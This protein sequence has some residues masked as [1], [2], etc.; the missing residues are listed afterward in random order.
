MSRKEIIET[1]LRISSQPSSL[2]ESFITESP[3]MFLFSSAIAFD[4]QIEYL[5]YLKNLCSYL[6]DE[7]DC[8]KEFEINPDIEEFAD[9]IEDKI[10]TD[11]RSIHTQIS[12]YY[13]ENFNHL[14]G[15]ERN[16]ECCN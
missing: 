16:E 4:L 1:K 2:E 11:L 6:L 10:F 8:D 15:G 7:P 5:M 9:S 13:F 12:D 3:D 14:I